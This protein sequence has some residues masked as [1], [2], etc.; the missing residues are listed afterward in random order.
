MG[1]F[2]VKYDEVYD[3]T[4]RLLNQV[5]S[6]IV[7]RTN[8][9]YRNIQQTLSR[10]DGAA[11]ASL[12]NAMEENRLKALEAAAVLDKLLRFIATSTKQI[13]VNEQRI[14]RGMSIGRK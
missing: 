4:S 12:M 11:N 6:N 13:E 9:D 8:N 5:R 3:E 14:A 7:E 2:N 1:T 10:A